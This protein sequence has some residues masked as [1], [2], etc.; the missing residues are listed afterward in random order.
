ME[1]KEILFPRSTV[2]MIYLGGFSM[3]KM[4][5]D[6][7]DMA[8]SD[9]NYLLSQLPEKER[10]DVLNALSALIQRY[11]KENSVEIP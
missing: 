6:G 8:V 3:I 10:Q 11:A 2:S 4:T 1:N 5:V 9:L 7:N